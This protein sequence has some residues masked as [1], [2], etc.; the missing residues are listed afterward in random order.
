M[1][2]RVNSKGTAEVKQSEL[3][4][5][6]AQLQHQNQETY[7]MLDRIQKKLMVIHDWQEPPVKSNEDKL[8][9]ENTERAA[10]SMVDKLKDALRSNGHNV[11]RL[12][13]VLSHLEQIA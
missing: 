8:E 2:D 11:D 3:G 6:L 4:F 10:G 9:L 5:V 7:E 1:E 13:N 12:R